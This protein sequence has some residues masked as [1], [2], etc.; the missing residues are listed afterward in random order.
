MNVLYLHGFR[1]SPESS[2][3]KLVAM[4]VKRYPQVVRLECPVLPVSPQQA[5]N[6]T[7][8][9]ATKLLS[10]AGGDPASL[11]LIGSSLGGFYAIYIAEKLGCKAVLLNPGIMADES[12][13]PYIGEHTYY[14]DPTQ[15]FHFTQ[16]HVD[17]LIELKTPHITRPDRYYLLAAKGDELL[18][19]KDMVDFCQ[20]S[21]LVVLEGG[22]HG[23]TDFE[24]H[25]DAVM[26]WIVCRPS[27]N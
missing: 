2:K 23:L 7:M 10:L 8:G 5:I 27:D 11:C 12:L 6:L 9:L 16:Q 26:R 20:G 13:K 24:E 17:E 22:D 21:W 4:A 1:S 3:A 18:N 15:K 19:W 14:H 25:V